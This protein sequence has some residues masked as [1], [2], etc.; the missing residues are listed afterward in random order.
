VATPPETPKPRNTQTQALNRRE[1]L[2]Q[3]YLPLG[4]TLLAAAVCMGLTIA[5]AYGARILNDRP[6]ADVSAMYLTAIAV[7]GA[8]P[9]LAVVVGLA[10]GAWY[11]LREVP[12]YLKIAQDFMRLVAARAAEYSKQVANVFIAPRASAAGARGALNRA[13]SAI[14]PGRKA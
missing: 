7:A 8:L 1:S 10:A 4:A 6:W 14:F 2:W 12:P 11:V 9:V 3:I 13:R 5:S